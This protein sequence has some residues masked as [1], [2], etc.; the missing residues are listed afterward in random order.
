MIRIFQVR[1]EKIWWIKN[2]KNGEKKQ[3]KENKIDT[4]LK[5]KREEFIK[6]HTKKNSNRWESRL[7]YISLH[8]NVKKQWQKITV[9]MS[10]RNSIITSQH[11]SRVIQSFEV[12]LLFFVY[13]GVLPGFDQGFA[14]ITIWIALFFIDLRIAKHGL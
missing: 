9:S 8:P 3:P 12:V 4:M 14:K 13:S 1:E 2:L 10:N 11:I 7:W 5:R 6:R